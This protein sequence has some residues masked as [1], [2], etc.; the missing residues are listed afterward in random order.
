M[1]DVFL[2]GTAHMNPTYLQEKVLPEMNISRD[3]DTFKEGRKASGI[4]FMTVAYGKA[5]FAK[6]TK[7][8]GK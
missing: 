7:L 5:T 4:L 1:G 3:G 6:L 8:F 2:K